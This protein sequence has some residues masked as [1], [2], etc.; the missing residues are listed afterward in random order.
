MWLKYL[1][2][3]S[4]CQLLNIN[5]EM[6]KTKKRFFIFLQCCVAYFLPLDCAVKQTPSSP[7]YLSQTPELHKSRKHFNALKKEWL[8]TPEL[9]CSLQLL[10]ATTHGIKAQSIKKH[11]KRKKG[12]DRAWCQQWLSVMEEGSCDDR[13]AS[14]AGPLM[15]LGH[16]ESNGCQ[17]CQHHLS[18]TKM[19]QLDTQ[20]HAR[21]PS[22]IPLSFQFEGLTCVSSKTSSFS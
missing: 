3:S 7:K 9:R 14:S 2:E 16:F 5:P 12:L 20:G 11:G 10:C 19:G 4:I 8:Q 6:L 1:K 13:W 21:P 22:N 18:H 17:R 15:Q